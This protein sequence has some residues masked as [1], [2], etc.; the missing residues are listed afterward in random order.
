M[1]GGEAKQK[2]I[3]NTYQDIFVEWSCVK[4]IS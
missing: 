3:I 2:E 4:V 1:L